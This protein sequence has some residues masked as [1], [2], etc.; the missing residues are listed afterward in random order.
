MDKQRMLHTARLA[1]RFATEAD[2]PTIMALEQHPDNRSFVCQGTEEQHRREVIDP[3]YILLVFTSQDDDSLIGY[4]LVWLNRVS[5]WAELR[6]MVITKKGQGY[7]REALNGLFSYLFDEILVNKVW[8]DV[9][10]HNTVGITLY[11]SV[12]M[13]C[14]GRLRQNFYDERLG[15]LDQF[16]YSRLKSEHESEKMQ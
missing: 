8:L 15:Y 5:N 14:D 16:I 6:R 11:E 4:C 1:L 9:Y 2:I 10:P 13:H 3:D 12:G 7:G